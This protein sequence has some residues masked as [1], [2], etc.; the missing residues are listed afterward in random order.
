MENKILFASFT[1]REID[2]MVDYYKT[3]V[4]DTS[5]LSWL[6]TISKQETVGDEY[7][8][9]E[10]FLSKFFND[11]S[12]GAAYIEHLYERVQ[13][14]LQQQDDQT[15]IYEQCILKYVPTLKPA[16]DYVSKHQY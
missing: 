5:S 8:K 4:V 7:V 16:F 3:I 9:V 13:T 1:Q 14:L 15:V 6:A 2:H 11:P 10:S 12:A